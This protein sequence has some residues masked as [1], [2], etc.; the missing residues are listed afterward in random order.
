VSGVQGK[1]PTFN[2]LITK[3]GKPYYRCGGGK[4]AW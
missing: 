2:N 3:T 4:D 1:K